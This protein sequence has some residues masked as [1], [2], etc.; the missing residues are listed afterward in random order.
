MHLL[1]WL[2]VGIYIVVLLG[3]GFYRS[4]KDLGTG[5][6]YILA[7]RKLS[8]P[9]FV[10]TLVATWY[11]GILGVG[12]NTYL[13][14]IQTWFIFALPYYVFAIL[15]ALFLAPKIRNKHFSSIPDHFRDYFGPSAG[16]ISA[17]LIMILV[18]PA[19]YILSMGILL[20][21]TLGWELQPAILISALLSLLYIWKGGFRSIIRTDFL[22]F[23]LMF[24][25]FFILLV[26]TWGLSDNPLTLTSTL[27]E[28]FFDPMG[29]HSLQ[30]II[31][32]FFI[33]LWTFVDPGFY[34]RTAAAS[35][36]KIAQK[37]ILVSVGFWFIFDILIITTGLYAA[38]LYPNIEAA[39]SYPEMASRILPPFM[40]GI[41]LVGLFSTIMSTI[42]SNG[43]LSAITFGR[44]I[45]L[46][47]HQKDDAEETTHIQKGLVVM[48]FLAVLL[49]ISIPSIVTLWYFIG[50]M[51]VPGILFPFIL[52]FTSV[53]LSENKCV[54]VIIIPVLVSATWFYYGH[55]SDNYPWHLEPFYP[56]II[57]SA[58]LIGLLKN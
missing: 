38:A 46:R 33:A 20:Q 47:V 14:G 11:G 23:G 35:S 10:A 29:Q 17:C 36:P 32:W 8:L 22:Q 39:M 44:D 51:V 3:L 1:D 18:S 2:A 34:Q 13:Y 5:S 48:T 9:G 54:F 42:D 37:G 50:S 12:E 31:V 40:Y 57:S 55:L 15:F 30:Y 49:A 16:I 25:G 28:N 19:P 26:F 6:D 43:F 41:F 4:K 53:K 45:I 24:F 7:G 21:H 52:T 27:S 56:G 58:L